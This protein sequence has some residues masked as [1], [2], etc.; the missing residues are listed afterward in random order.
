MA[1]LL[2]KVRYFKIGEQAPKNSCFKGIVTPESIFGGAG[3]YFNYCERYVDKENTSLMKYTSRYGFTYSD[4][5]YL[6]SKEKKQAFIDKGKQSIGKEGSIV[7]E[8]V[9][10]LADY[11]VA[12]KYD[13]TGQEQFAAVTSVIL[14]RFLTTIGLD[15][16]NV[17]WWQDFHPE[18]RTSTTPHPHIHLLFFE[19]EPTH[20][21]ARFYGKLPKKALNKFKMMFASEMI[22]REDQSIY[23]D[24]FNDINFSKRNLL[25]NIKHTNFDRVDSLKDL[26]AILPKSGRLQINSTNMAPYRQEV[27]KVVD[28]LLESKECK[29]VWK[30]FTDSLDKYEYL[31]NQKVDSNISS[32]K[33]IEVTK[34]KEQIAN[35]ILSGRKDYEE[36]NKYENII[37][38]VNYKSSDGTKGRTYKDKD[39]IRNRL[40]HRNSGLAT[41]RMING[42]LAKRQNEIEMEIEQYLNQNSLDFNL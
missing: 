38:N 5:G 42:M 20:T 37:K 6:D 22:K 32:R 15:P 13:L 12:S 16:N 9:C 2:C 33:D 24:L 39:I 14:P 21:F 26:Y 28:K 29:D 41:K 40:N 25:D 19:D 4:D 1:D 23:K 27:Y 17:S 10:S 34:I 36:E 3:S 31:I 11:E 35:A 8:I 30:Q 7:Y 18:N